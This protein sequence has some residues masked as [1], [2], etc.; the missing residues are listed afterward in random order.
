MGNNEI[1]PVEGARNKMRFWPK[2]KCPRV[3][4]Y[5][6]PHTTKLSQKNVKHKCNTGFASRVFMKNDIGY[7]TDA[8]E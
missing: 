4:G 3:Y 1:L 7:P 6:K 2:R 5:R 8:G